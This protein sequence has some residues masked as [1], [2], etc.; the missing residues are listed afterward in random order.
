MYDVV[1]CEHYISKQISV[2]YG[3]GFRH[4][5]QTRTI[6]ADTLVSPLKYIPAKY[7]E[8][9]CQ[10]LRFSWKQKGEGAIWVLN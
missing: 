6:K 3:K 4:Q 8:E 1:K 5:D 7:K 10:P 2:W 9:H